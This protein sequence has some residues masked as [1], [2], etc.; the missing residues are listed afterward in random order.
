MGKNRY[1][2]LFFTQ[3][4]AISYSRKLK[5]AGIDNITRPVPRTLSSSC[6]ICV[7]TE[8]DQDLLQFLT[9]DVEKLCIEEKGTYEAIYEV[10]E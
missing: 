7:E 9:E 3:Y 1:I 5:N 10:Q 2:V 6:G 4:G 8:T